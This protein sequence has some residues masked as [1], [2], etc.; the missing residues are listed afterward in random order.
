MEKQPQQEPQEQAKPKQVEKRNRFF[1]KEILSEDSKQTV[2]K[3][4]HIP[5]KGEKISDT[6]RTD[7]K[8][9][10]RQRLSDLNGRSL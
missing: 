6:I 4:K 2:M 10:P 9:N 5:H 8:H 1:S 3:V 7:R